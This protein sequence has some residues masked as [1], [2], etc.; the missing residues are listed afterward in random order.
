MAW[1]VRYASAMSDAV[2]PWVLLPVVGALIGYVTNRLAVRMIFRPI[3]PKRILGFK[4]QGLIGRRQSEI[5]K[6]IGDVVG[7]HLVT[8]DDLKGALDAIDLEE[9]VDRAFERGLAPK[10]EELRKLPLVGGFLTDERVN[11]LRRHAVMGVVKHRDELEAAVQKGLENGVDVHKLVE[12][13]VA[14]FSVEK[15]ESLILS[16]ASRELRAIEVLGGVLGGL[17]GLAQ[18]AVLALL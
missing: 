8:A 13:K 4:V 15:V 5:A 9:V 12:S 11:D 7:D 2:L 3:E 17:V 1:I 6:S 10:I 14:T 16:V 18:A